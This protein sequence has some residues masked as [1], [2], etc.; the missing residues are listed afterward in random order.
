MVSDPKVPQRTR[1]HPSPIKTSASN[2]H[3][4]QPATRE[5]VDRAIQHE[6]A[7]GRILAHDLAGHMFGHLVPLD[8]ARSILQQFISSG[9]L[10]V[11]SE[12]EDPAIPLDPPSTDALSAIHEAYENAGKHQKKKRTEPTY[13][14]RWRDFPQ[15]MGEEDLVEFL[16]KIINQAFFFAKPK[17]HQETSFQNRFATL[18]DRGHTIRLPYEAD[19]EDMH[20]DFILL[21]IEVFSESG[22]LDQ[23]YINF[24]AL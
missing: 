5:P 8:L 11:S 1:N 2:R 19:L 18:V 14:W 23:R 20:P 7:D 24:M 9:T 22:D 6:L 12:A 13:S 3:S 4:G 10:Q 15:R 16:N 17:L 21:P